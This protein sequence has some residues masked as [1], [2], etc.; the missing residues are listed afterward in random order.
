M[1][2][3]HPRFWDEKRIYSIT[4]FWSN[5]CW[6]RLSKIKYLITFNFTLVQNEMFGSIY[7]VNGTSGFEFLR[8]IYNELTFF[9][10]IFERNYHDF[11]L[12]PEQT[13]QHWP[14]GIYCSVSHTMSAHIISSQLPSEKNSIITLLFKKS[15]L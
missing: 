1:K 8:D 5:F 11:L 6:K 9:L 14:K 3:T 4:S 2:A 15:W 7:R 13:G 10:F 12:L